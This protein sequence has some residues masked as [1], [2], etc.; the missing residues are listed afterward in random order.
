MEALRGIWEMDLAMEETKVDDHDE[1]TVALYKLH[2]GPVILHVRGEKQVF[3]GSYR[4]N[5]R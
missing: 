2:G 4:S 3:R 5:L 1:I